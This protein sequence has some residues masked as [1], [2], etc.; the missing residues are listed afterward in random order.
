MI[1]LELLLAGV[2]SVA[3]ETVQQ[4]IQVDSRGDPL[5]IHANKENPA[6]PAYRRP[7]QKVPKNSLAMP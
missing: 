4:I 1:G 7:L 6:R 2:P 5:A 3:P